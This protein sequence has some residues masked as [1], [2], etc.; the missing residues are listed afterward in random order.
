[1][2]VFDKCQEPGCSGSYTRL[3]D[4]SH[5]DQGLGVPVLLLGATVLQC[6]TCGAR[7]ALLPGV[8]AYGQDVA[9]LIVRKHGLVTRR[10]IKLLRQ[11]LR[12]N[13]SELAGELHVSREIVSQWENGKRPISPHK[14]SR[15]RL[16]VLVHLGRTGQ[17]DVEAALQR[18]FMEAR[19]ERPYR[20][21]VDYPPAQE[22]PEEATAAA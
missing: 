19:E 7:S 17:A 3:V 21:P 10:E 13:I 18:P 20:L 9:A 5:L 22:Q 4:Q 8:R 6:D 14:D 11:V 1:M 2:G 15:L 12:L 16:L